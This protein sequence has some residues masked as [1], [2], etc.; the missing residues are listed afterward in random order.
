MKKFSFVPIGHW[1]IDKSVSRAR[2]KRLLGTIRFENI[3]AR[4]CSE[5][6][7]FGIRREKGKTTKR[8][9]HRYV[10]T[11]SAN[12]RTIDLWHNSCGGYR[13][14][15]YL[16]PAIGDSANTYAA[17]FLKAATE[18]LIQRDRF[19]KRY[20]PLV[21]KSICHPETRLWIH[22]GRWGAK[23]PD[24][25]LQV[26]RWQ[27]HREVDCAKVTKRRN[28][29]ALMPA[30]EFRPA[31]KGQWLNKDGSP[32]SGKPKADRARQINRYGFT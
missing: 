16:K 6:R 1:Q 14:Q 10:I 22:Q 24:R 3:V 27:D 17:D 30:N 8:G 2:R 19:R 12:R 28:W 32:V 29:G 13:A 25:V 4:L 23:L 5:A 15:Y 20:W 9:L 31:L 7:I 21:A 18:H 26:L 11:L